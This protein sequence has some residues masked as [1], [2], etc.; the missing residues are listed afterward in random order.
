ACTRST[1]RS[2]TPADRRRPERARGSRSTRAAST[3]TSTSRA[4]TCSCCNPDGIEQR[5]RRDRTSAPARASEGLVKEVA[6]QFLYSPVDLVTNPPHRFEGLT[7]RV[8]ENPV[9]VLL[10]GIDRAGVPASHRDDDVGSANDLVRQRL[11]ELL[12]HVDPEFLH[13]RDDG[14][15]D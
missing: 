6:D 1:A 11:G 12:G 4:T 8:V 3:S 14:G 13:R 2:T 15:S 7:R 9:L 5:G 10:A